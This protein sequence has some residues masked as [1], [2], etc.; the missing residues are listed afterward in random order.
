MIKM[1][2]FLSRRANLS[3]ESSSCIEK[4]D[5]TKCFNCDYYNN[6]DIFRPTE[7]YGIVVGV[8]YRQ[9]RCKADF[10]NT[11]Y[12]THT[13]L[14]RDTRITSPSIPH[15]ARPL[16]MINKFHSALYSSTTDANLSVIA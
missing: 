5:L 13:Y 1:I 12:F 6:F 7:H 16:L 15:R 4:S 14:S 3:L 8:N 2:E 9:I 11:I 10:N